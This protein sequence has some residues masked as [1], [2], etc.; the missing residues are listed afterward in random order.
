MYHEISTMFAFIKPQCEVAVINHMEVSWNWGTPIYHPFLD[1]V[2]PNK[3]HPAIGVPPFWETP[4][5]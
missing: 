3:N 1:A 2:F 4:I 5:S